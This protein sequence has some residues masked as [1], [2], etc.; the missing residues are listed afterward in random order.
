MGQTRHL[1]FHVRPFLLRKLHASR[2]DSRLLQCDRESFRNPRYISGIHAILSSKHPAIHP[3]F[4]ITQRTNT[5]AV[6]RS[7]AQQALLHP[8][9]ATTPPPRSY[10]LSLPP[11]MS[12][13]PSAAPRPVPSTKSSTTSTYRAP[14]RAANSSPPSPTAPRARVPVASSICQRTCP[15]FQRRFRSPAP[16]R[17]RHWLVLT[18]RPRGGRLWGRGS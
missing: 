18:L 12:A 17:G 4:L 7:L 6:P 15:R 1:H 11:A 3:I 16:R 8:L 13:P 10:P 14:C 9:P 5:T 2:G